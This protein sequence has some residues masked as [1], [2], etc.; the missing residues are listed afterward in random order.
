[1]TRVRVEGGIMTADQ[2]NAMYAP[3]QPI[4]L[5]EDDGSKTYTQTR[6]IA[7]ELS[8]GTFVVLVDGKTGGYDLDRIK[9]R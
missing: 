5:T 9:A 8:P 7:W 1:M 3:H 2:W 4:E 6:S